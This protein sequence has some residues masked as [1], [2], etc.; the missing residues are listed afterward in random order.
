MQIETAWTLFNVGTNDK[1]KKREKI[2][3]SQKF[4]KVVVNHT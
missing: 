2:M 4:G 1:G 3:K